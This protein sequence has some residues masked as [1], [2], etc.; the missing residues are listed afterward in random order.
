ML[1]LVILV[2]FAIVLI[3]EA[4]ENALEEWSASK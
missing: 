3:G 2:L 4:K 1:D